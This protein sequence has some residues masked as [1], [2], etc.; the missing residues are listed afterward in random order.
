MWKPIFRTLLASTTCLGMSQLAAPR[1]KAASADSKTSLRTGSHGHVSKPTVQ[2]NAAP[3][4]VAAGQPQA[5]HAMP[6]N[7]P[8][9]IHV[10]RG[11][12]I[13]GGLMK[14]QTAP[15]AVNSITAAAIAQR[16]AAASPLQ[17]IASMP[18]VNFG[19]SDAL[20][21]TIRN[22]LAVRGLAESEMGWVINGAPGIDQAYYYPY[23]ESWAD[24]ENIADVTLIP[25]TSRINDPVQSATGG[26]FI[27]TTRD[28]SDKYGGLLSYSAGSYQAQRVFARADSGYIGHSGIKMYA[29]YS[30]T[31]ENNFY[32]PG[33]SHRTHVDFDV[34]KDWGDIGTSKLFISYNDLVNAR[35]NFMTLS[36]WEKNNA[37]DNNFSE[38]DYA[39]TYI[40]GKTTNYWKSYIYKRTNVLLS[41]QNEFHLTD[42]LA[43]HFTPYFHYADVNSPGQTSINPASVYN[44]DQKIAIDTNGLDL[45]NGQLNVMSNSNQ[46][47]YSTGVN[48]YLQYRV[49]K[50][51]HLLFGYW[52]DNWTMTQ[53]NGLSP[54]DYQGNTANDDGKYILR[55]A[56]GVPVAGTHFQESSQIN[57]FYLSD[58][59]SFLNDRLEL[60]AGIK[61]MMDY[62]SGTNMV[63]GPQYHY[64]QAM[65]Q[66]MPRVTVSY[67]INKDMQIYAN[68]MTNMRP[69]VPLSTYPTS[70]GVGTGKVVQQGAT[71]VQPEYSIG[72]ELGFRYHGLFTF[73]LALF[74]MNMT[75]HQVATTQILN[76]ANVQS[77][78]SVGGETMRG[79][80]VELAAPTFHGLS[81]YVNGQYL[82]ATTDN[83][84]RVGND[85]LPTAG[86]IAVMS[87]KFMATVG[88]NYTKGPFFAN[89]GFKWV[90]SQYSTF[91]N[92]QSMPA[93]KTVDLGFGYHFPS[94]HMLSGP[95]LR[96]NFTN[97]TNV[98]YISSVAGVAA[99]AQTMRGLGGTLISG[100][101]P[102][103]YIGAPMTVMMTAT[104]GF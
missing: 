75:N 34:Q 55:S 70:Y 26:E 69:P 65:F 86:K 85:S 63:S 39:G 25:G 78:I 102:S 52:Y 79:V 28:P 67:K 40:P 77:A 73:D 94:F 64:S 53:L 92:D 7:E 35:Q 100:S 90:D 56:S 24:N 17:L 83:N 9:E 14:R 44:G 13:G 91:M 12:P 93:Y 101:T 95:T 15:E 31:A 71:G 51:N 19:S 82:H 58:T 47:M 8:E 42:R 103:Y 45:V 22:N 4:K 3:V 84:F 1:V 48:T 49:S 66:P 89:L 60:S 29:S 38:S 96:L 43:L 21:L 87:P 68:G 18:G 74:N 54:M 23:T 33:R 11:R 88:I 32:G 59:Q 16:T 36:Q 37:V 104:A 80:T 61:L 81:P 50:T 46:L 57:E 76:G 5:P 97:L 20:G 10:T 98:K 6:I 62:V 41:L 30:Y 2:S 27:E 72:E 99:N